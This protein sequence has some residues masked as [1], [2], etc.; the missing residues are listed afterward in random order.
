MALDAE[1]VRRF[2]EAVDRVNQLQE[3]LGM[4]PVNG[5][6]SSVITVNAGG[7]GVWIAT[8]ACLVMLAVSGFLMMLYLDVREDQRDTAAHLQTIYMLVPDLRKQV[9]ARIESSKPTE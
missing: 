4:S 5:M 3:R 6:N 9:E 2:G 1:D 8:T 7:V